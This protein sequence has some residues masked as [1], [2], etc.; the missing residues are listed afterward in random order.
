MAG[1][2]DRILVLKDYVE[3]LG[4]EVNIGKNRARG[5]KGFFKSQNGK[6]RI[7]IS[8]G[9]SD[10]E[11]LKILVHEFSH[12]VHYKY[13]KT[14]KSLDFIFKD[15]YKN[16]ENDL[17]NLTVDSIPK[18]TVSPLFNL[19]DE[20]VNDLNDY[21]KYFSEK[22][23]DY[24][25]NKPF[26]KIEKS[27]T[28]TELRYLLKYDRVKVWS[29]FRFKV[30]SLDNI[31]E[32]CGDT[33]E[34]ILMYLKLKSAQRKLRRINSKISRLNK[35]YNS[36]TELFARS[37]EYYICDK[38]RMKLKTP[39]LSDYYDSVVNSNKI[40]LITNMLKYL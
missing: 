34:D 38:E 36:P 8:K 37:F 27:I 12:F 29:G 16:Y 35:Y 28:K 19:K 10:A 2:R 20:I 15:T 26:Q 5:N 22:Y 25:A 18:S 13:D 31:D 40:P 23:P 1:Q 21:N 32:E 3:S 11:K 6:Y 4:I 30:I 9:I 39:D 14:L 33:S 7:D 17:I 24:V